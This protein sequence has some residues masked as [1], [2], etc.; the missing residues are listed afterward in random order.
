MCFV[1]YLLIPFLNL[2]IQTMNS[3]LHLR[4]IL[5]CLLVYSVIGTIP[6]ITLG[7]NYVSWFVVFVF[8]FLY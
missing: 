1:F 5:L 8:I 4:L 7:V 3:K 2:L 6:K